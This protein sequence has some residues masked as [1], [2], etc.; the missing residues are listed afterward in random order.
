MPLAT[1][2]QPSQL[3]RTLSAHGRFVA[4][5]PEWR[6]RNRLALYLLADRAFSPR[7]SK[8]AAA[9][10]LKLFTHLK[11][12]WQLVRPAKRVLPAEKI[13]KLL[14]QKCRTCAGAQPIT[15]ANLHK[16][17]GAHLKLLASLVALKKVKQ[18]PSGQPSI[19]AISK[20]LHFYN[21]KL[22]LIY[23]SEFIEHGLLKTFASEWRAFENYPQV[24]ESTFQKYL[25]YLF[26]ANSLLYKHEASLKH[27]VKAHLKQK[28]VPANLAKF[29]VQPAVLFEFLAL[30][31]RHLKTIRSS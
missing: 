12:H 15:L 28:G 29:A 10:F 8:T 20:L 14:M 5:K 6:Y 1:H 19:M 25:K 21:P 3:K 24:K 13:H 7:A 26:F 18:L 16:N 30:G 31:A 2:F 9:A 27:A 4:A 17:P 11:S 23:D 22:F